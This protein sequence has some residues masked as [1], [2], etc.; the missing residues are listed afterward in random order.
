MLMHALTSS[1]PARAQPAMALLLCHTLRDS[2]NAREHSKRQQGRRT[3]AL[4]A[5]AGSTEVL[6]DQPELLSFTQRAISQELLCRWLNALQA[7]LCRL[8]AAQAGR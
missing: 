3:L 5:R 8:Q 6:S 7:G 2:Y 4:F 1:R